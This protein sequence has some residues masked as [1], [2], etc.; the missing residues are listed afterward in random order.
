MG[1]FN[2]QR[3]Q[4]AQA[5]RNTSTIIHRA[6]WHG[7]SATFYINP[8]G[9]TWS[10]ANPPR[11][12][13]DDDNVEAALAQLQRAYHLAVYFPDTEKRILDFYRAAGSDIP[14]SVV[15]DFKWQPPL[16]GSHSS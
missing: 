12:F 2:R 15:L 6:N 4:R 14:D 11:T 13:I 1:L 10:Y 16:P 9:V 3:G 7:N 5:P 8:E